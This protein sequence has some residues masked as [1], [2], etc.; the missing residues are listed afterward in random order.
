M[1]NG[2]TEPPPTNVYSMTITQKNVV[3]ELRKKA[4]KAKY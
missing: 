1:E 2:F 4:N 3:V